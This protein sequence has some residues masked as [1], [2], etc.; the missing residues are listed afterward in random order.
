MA[1]FII[2]HV[3]TNAET[4][5]ETKATAEVLVNLDNITF[6]KPGKNDI[7]SHIFLTGSDNARTLINVIETLDEIFSLIKRS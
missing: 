7:G 2:V 1:R 4:N 3:Y 5:A 6:I